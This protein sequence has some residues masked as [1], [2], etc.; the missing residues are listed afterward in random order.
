MK[1]LASFFLLAASITVSAQT[2]EQIIDKFADATGG[3]DKWDKVENYTLKQSFVAN[4]PTDFDS[5]VNVDI[6][7][8]RMSRKKSIMK[9]DF[10]YIVDKDKGWLKIPMGSLDQN[11]KYNVKDLSD[12]EKSSMHGEIKDGIFPFF[13]YKAKGYTAKLGGTEKIDG[14]T[15]QELVLTKGKDSFT[16]FFDTSSGLLVKEIRKSDADTETWE[17]K[18]YAETDFGVKYPVSATFVSNK[19]KKLNKVTS[20]LEINHEIKDS[21][22]DK[23]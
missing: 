23:D 22:F 17:Y 15:A 21:V 13:D 7:N 19:Y 2:P 4:A 3:M 18:K 11:V 9:R 10:Y 1:K 20:D 8:N 12:K 14:K 6:E 5:E 16:Y